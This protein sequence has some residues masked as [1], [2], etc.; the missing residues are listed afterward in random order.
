M[1]MLA[2]AGA[3]NDCD[4][5]LDRA[6]VRSAQ[7]AVLRGGKLLWSGSTGPRA[8]R[9]VIA[10]VTKTYVA[11]IALRLVEEG[12]LALDEPLSTFVPEAPN[13]ELIT[14]RMLLRHRSGLR[15]YFDDPNVQRAL[16]DPDHRWTRDEVI[17]A[18]VRLGARRPPDSRFEYRNSNYILLGRVIE[19]AGGAKPEALLQRLV[20]RPLGLRRT[21][22]RRHAKLAAAPVPNDAIGQV[23]TDGGIATS[24]REL[25]KFTQALLRG[26]LL[27]R[28]S[29]QAMKSGSDANLGYGMGLEEYG[30]N[31]WWGHEGYYS[32][33]S[34]D[35][36]FQAHTG[37]TVSV[38]TDGGNATDLAGR[39][40]SA[41]RAS[42]SS[43]R[44]TA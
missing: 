11:T 24:A 29:L 43:C 42:R 19:I 6:N 5:V 27:R 16:R 39:L 26:K 2:F 12:R 35:T 15:E 28:A 7:A 23:W 38:V 25:A 14:V 36:S 41:T 22:F 13:A 20:A 21:S 1:L 9:F 10:S 34:A 40:R 32:P 44:R 30:R 18:I 4:R 8:E 33:Y 31:N 17:R 3:P 37:L